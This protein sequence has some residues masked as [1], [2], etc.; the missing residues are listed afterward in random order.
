MSPNVPVN[1]SYPN[2]FTH[3]VWAP[4]FS[5]STLASGNHNFTITLILSTLFL[6]HIHL[7]VT[8]SHGRGHCPLSFTLSSSAPFNGGIMLVWG[9]SSSHSE[10][11][12][13]GKPSGLSLSVPQG[14]HGVSQG[15][16]I[17]FLAELIAWSKAC[18]PQCSL[19]HSF[20]PSFIH[21]FFHS[22]VHS[23]NK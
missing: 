10:Q 21:S 2:S 13:H 20:I 14:M 23:L 5:F 4:S 9:P 19:I 16:R 17:L 1:I 3:G 15:C 11:Q 18:K 22:L 8:I 7:P 6:L 12:D